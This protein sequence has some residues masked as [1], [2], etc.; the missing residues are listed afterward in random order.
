[1]TYASVEARG[2]SGR[3]PAA[4]RGVGAARAG[5]TATPAAARVSPRRRLRSR[6]SKG[7]GSRAA[8]RSRAA[9][10]SRALHCPTLQWAS[11]LRPHMSGPAWAGSDDRATLEM[12]SRAFRALRAAL[13]GTRPRAGRCGR[14]RAR[15]LASSPK[16]PKGR[17]QGYYATGGYETSRWQIELARGH[18][19]HPP[20]RPLA[21]A[22]GQF[23]PSHLAS[24]TPP[25]YY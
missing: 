18:R 19:R 6:A 21:A 12:G 20:R 13:G 1:M 24:P 7:Y 23:A 2:G 8:A 4:R 9:P 3:A 5:E 16:P 17:Y 10:A 14:R 15:P 25:H 11:L 22:P